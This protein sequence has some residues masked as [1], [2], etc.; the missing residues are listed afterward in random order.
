[1]HSPTSNIGWIFLSKEDEGKTMKVLEMLQATGTVDEL[2]VGVVRNALS[3][4]MFPGITTIMTRAKYFFIVPRILHSYIHDN[5]GKEDVIEYL[6]K[7]ENELMMI[8]ANKVGFADNKGV[9]GI[10]VAKFNHEL[11]K[12]RHKELIRKPSAIYWNGIKSY[13][14]YIGDLSLANLLDKINRKKGDSSDLR[15]YSP[16]EGESKDEKEDSKYLFELPDRPKN[17]K[18]NIDIELTPQEANFLKN[19]II[20]QYPDSLL[21]YILK[22]ADAGK[23]FLQA[24]SFSEMCELPFIEKLSEINQKIVKHALYFWKLLEG[25]HIRYN[26]LLHEKHGSESQ[27]LEFIK[28]WEL[29]LEEIKQI[30]WKAFDMG[31]VWSI[32]LREKASVKQH[33]KTFINQWIEAIKN[34]DSDINKM[35]AWIERQ[36]RLNKGVRS[37]LRLGNDERYK[38]WVGISNMEYRFSNA[39]TIMRDILKNLK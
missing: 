11:P 32:V 9:I 26:I 18:E 23:Q 30:D 5:K 7:E 15:H 35:D 8:L 38:E 37:K 22:N 19:K 12:Q 25:A 33:T 29:W 3:D 36:E 34:N 10:S 39:K 17:W 24:K 27:K 6:R 13:R 20:D 21:T 16:M 31:F 1:M 28:R 14:L 2:G 4:A